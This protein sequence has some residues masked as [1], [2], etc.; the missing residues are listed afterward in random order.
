M[1]DEQQTQQSDDGTFT[2]RDVQDWIDSL[3]PR[4]T[5]M[6]A[7][8]IGDREFRAAIAALGEAAE[9]VA[10]IARNLAS[11]GERDKSSAVRSVVG[12]I[13]R[14]QRQAARAGAEHAGRPLS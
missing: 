10:Q 7:H 8:V 4:E 9:G 11:K 2:H 6:L 5:A 3:T 1:S 12:V 13:L 14:V